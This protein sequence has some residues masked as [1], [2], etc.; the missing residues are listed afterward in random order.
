VG[1]VGAVFSVKVKFGNHSGCNCAQSDC[2][3]RGRT[4]SG[5][6]SHA[7][8]GYVAVMYTRRN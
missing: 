7:K 8:D 5:D 2:T 4:K 1:T 6:G 3:L